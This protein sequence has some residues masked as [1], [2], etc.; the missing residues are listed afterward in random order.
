MVAAA[1]IVVVIRKVV[2]LG[3]TAGRRRRPAEVRRS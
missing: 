2:G 1:A 3:L